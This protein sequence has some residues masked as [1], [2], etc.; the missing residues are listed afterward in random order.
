MNQKDEDGPGIGIDDLDGLQA[1]I[2][3]MLVNVT[4]RRIAIQSETD[5]LVNWTESQIKPKKGSPS[6]TPPEKGSK[7]RKN[8]TD[9]HQRV[10]KRSRLATDSIVKVQ[11][12]SSCSSISSTLS[13]ASSSSGAST[14]SSVTV[15]SATDV[16]PVKAKSKS[17]NVTS[18]KAQQ[19]Q[20]SQQTEQDSSQYLQQQQQ[21]NDIPDRFCAFID[22]YCA[23]VRPEHVKFLEDLIK[24][25]E[26]DSLNEY[27]KIPNKGKH[28][29]TKW[30]TSSADDA[31]VSSKSAKGDNRKKG[32][33]S[34]IIFSFS[35][36]E[37][38]FLGNRLFSFQPD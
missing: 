15:V 30:G 3:S 4:K 11:D 14:A 9:E 26:D 13:S 6:K 7:K 34:F 23:P 17:K 28:Y 10:S 31:S 35:Y 12:S 27:Y 36:F 21:K 2:E 20:S 8:Q 19:L 5:A 29:S 38:L 32:A 33:T 25:Y 1:E 37:S 24:G 18:K 16:K 22:Q